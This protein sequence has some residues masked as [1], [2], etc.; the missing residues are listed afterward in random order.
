MLPKLIEHR[1]INVFFTRSASSVFP[2]AVKLAIA[3]INLLISPIGSNRAYR[4]LISVP[5][6]DQRGGSDGSQKSVGFQRQNRY[7]NLVATTVLCFLAACEFSVRSFLQPPWLVWLEP[8]VL[9]I[10]KHLEIG[11]EP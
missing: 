11:E 1:F 3:E 5:T 7:K 2:D 4:N 9:S 8:V 6:V 10:G